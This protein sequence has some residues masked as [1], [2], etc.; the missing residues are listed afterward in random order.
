MG[1]PIGHQDNGAD[2]FNYADPVAVQSQ[3]D[4]LALKVDL[5]KN[6]PALL[7]WG[8]VCTSPHLPSA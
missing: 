2:G 1:Q 7:A 8:D 5:Y 4:A 6:H 3:I